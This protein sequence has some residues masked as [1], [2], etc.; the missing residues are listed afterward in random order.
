[1]TPMSEKEFQD[2]LLQANWFM[3][4][5]MDENKKEFQLDT[6]QRDLPAAEVQRCEDLVVRRRRR[7]GHV[8]LVERLGDLLREVL[9]ED[10]DHRA[11]PQR[12]Q[13]LVG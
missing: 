8:G 2:Y 13:R 1:M 11:L 7:V 4:G 10:V 12:R 9:V 5:R 3:R 6:F